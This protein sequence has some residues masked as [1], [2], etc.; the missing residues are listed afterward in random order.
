MINTKSIP[1][2]VIR[3]LIYAYEEQEA[4]VRLNGKNSEKFKI[5]NG[6]RQGSVISPYLLAHAI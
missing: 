6:T 3:T 5:G 1:P 4:W 2:I